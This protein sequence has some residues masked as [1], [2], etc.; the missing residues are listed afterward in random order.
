MASG[1]TL[2]EVPLNFRRKKRPMET[3]D[4]AWGNPKRFNNYWLKSYW[5]AKCRSCGAMVGRATEDELR[6]ALAHFKRGTVEGP[7]EAL[8]PDPENQIRP[9]DL[10]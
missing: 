10:K 2:W 5:T 4:H 1:C 3:C 7:A 6:E 8:T 9:Q